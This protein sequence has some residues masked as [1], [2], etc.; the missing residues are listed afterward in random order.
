[1]MKKA[2]LFLALGAT[3]SL[4]A[5]TLATPENYSSNTTNDETKIAWMTWDEVREQQRLDKEDPNRKP[6]KVLIDFYTDWCGWCKRM[7]RDTYGNPEIVKLVNELYYPVKF[8]AESKDPLNFS[9]EVV[10]LHSE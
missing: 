8:D 2:I 3:V 9:D 6:K 5:F 10:Y 1:M 4:M 7:D